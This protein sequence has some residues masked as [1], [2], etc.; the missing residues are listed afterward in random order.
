MVRESASNSLL[1]FAISWLRKIQETLNTVRIRHQTTFSDSI[2]QQIQRVRRENTFWAV[3]GQVAT[4]RGLK[5][6]VQIAIVFHLSTAANSDVIKVC[7]CSF[8][9]CTFEQVIHDPSEARDGDSQ[10]ERYPF[11]LP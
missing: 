4:S 6:F 9:I 10:P 1:F 11:P 2:T 8:V 7:K 5:K 3:K